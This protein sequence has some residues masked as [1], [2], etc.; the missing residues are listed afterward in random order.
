MHFFQI[1]TMEGTEGISIGLKECSMGVLRNL[2]MPVSC[3]TN[4]D[5]YLIYNNLIYSHKSAPCTLTIQGPVP[6]KH[7][8]RIQCK[9]KMLSEINRIE[10]YVKLYGRRKNPNVCTII[11]S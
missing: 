1:L 7:P 10:W 5:L 9:I 6:K 4:S 11:N 2:D 3:Y 8:F